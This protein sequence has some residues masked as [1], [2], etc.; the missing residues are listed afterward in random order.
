MLKLCGVL[1]SRYEC[2]L[3]RH[4]SRLVTFS[5]Q[6]RGVD[7][8]TPIVSSQTSYITR[9]LYCV[10][11]LSAKRLRG[12]RLQSQ[13]KVHTE[14]KTRAKE[15]F[16]ERASAFTVFFFF[17][18]GGGAG[19]FFDFCTN[20][21]ARNTE[22]LWLAVM[23]NSQ[24]FYFESWKLA[25]NSIQLRLVMWIAGLEQLAFCCDP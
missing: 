19:I 25:D 17:L 3:F 12:R 15:N 5:S 7:S 24:F 1:K 20:H 14:I 11:G 8:K 21:G 16:G 6:T 4:P 22:G 13:Q 2:R 10:Q 9:T 23:H 18:G